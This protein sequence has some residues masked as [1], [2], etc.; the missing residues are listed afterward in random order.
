[1]F[2]TNS[3]ESSL[4]IT[5][6]QASVLSLHNQKC[7]KSCYAFCFHF[8]P[9]LYLSQRL[10]FAFTKLFATSD[11]FYFFNFSGRSSRFILFGFPETLNT[12]ELSFPINTLLFLDAA[13]QLLPLALLSGFPPL[14]I[15]GG[16]SGP[17]VFPAYTS[18]LGDP[19]SSYGISHHQCPVIRSPHT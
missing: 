10:C 7:Q 13:A 3:T 12:T 11:L 5:P 6:P 1:M 15:S 16:Y 19:I 18:W 2:I 4:V 17:P 9:N 14:T 8:L